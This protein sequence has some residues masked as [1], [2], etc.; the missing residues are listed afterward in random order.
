MQKPKTVDEY[1]S[2]APAEAKPFLHQIR[3]IIRSAAP[4]AQEKISYGMPFYSYKGRLVYFAHAKEHVG[5]YAM[6]AAMDAL[7]SEVKPYRTSKATL[8]FPLDEK[9]PVA[10]IKKLVKLQMKKNEEKEKK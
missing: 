3:K 6:M 4:S 8:R 2:R 9:L 7:K 1:L 5:V 10:L